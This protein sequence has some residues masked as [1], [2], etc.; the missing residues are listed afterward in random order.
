VLTAM[1]VRHGQGF[2][3]STPRAHDDLYP[4]AVRRA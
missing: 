4:A 3:F 2:H 1:G